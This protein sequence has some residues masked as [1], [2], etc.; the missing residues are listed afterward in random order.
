[1]SRLAEDICSYSCY[2]F[3]HNRFHHYK[4]RTNLQQPFTS[5]DVDPP[6]IFVCPPTTSGA[7]GVVN[8]ATNKEDDNRVDNHEDYACDTE[9]V[10][11]DTRASEE[12]IMK[13]GEHVKMARRAQRGAL[14][15]EK[16][17][18]AKA[19]R[20]NN[21][22]HPERTYTLIIDYGQNMA[23]LPYFGE[24]QPGDTY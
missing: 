14:V 16:M 17:E 4:Q 7:P 9:D 1:V 15:N 21:V 22:K 23:S 11:D 2:K 24:S 20:R 12:E 5:N 3:L 8:N 18:Q 10:D 13:A 6:S 19:D